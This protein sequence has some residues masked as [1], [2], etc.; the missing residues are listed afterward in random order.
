[1]GKSS[2]AKYPSYS[3]GAININGKNVAK[4]SKN[5]NSINSDYY[6]GETE[7][8]IY[9]SIQDNMSE[10]LNSLLDISDP[11]REQWQNQLN[12]MQNTGIQNIND[13]YTPLQNNLKNDIASRFGNLDNSIFLDKLGAITNDKSKAMADLTNNLLTAQNDLYKQEILNRINV[14]ALLDNLN[15]SINANILNYLEM[16]GQNANSGNQHNQAS[17][18]ASM[19]RNNYQNPFAKLGVS[20]LGLLGL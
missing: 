4:I 16:A 17:Y 14:L 3:G 9:D 19:Q 15:N 5:G 20:A 13:I 7:K 11:L 8:K 2:G 1:M 10:R 12:A 18:Q 6:M